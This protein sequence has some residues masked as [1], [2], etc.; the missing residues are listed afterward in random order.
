MRNNET[1]PLG[2]KLRQVRKARNVSQELI[3]NATQ[4]TI[5][6]VSHME[7]G[8]APCEPDTLLQIKKVLNVETMPLLDSERPAFKDR[9]LNFYDLILEWKNEEAKEIGKEL[10]DIKFLPFERELNTYYNLFNSRLL[11]AEGEFDKATEILK[12]VERYLP[13]ADDELTFYYY[14]TMGTLNLRTFHD[15]VA[16]DFFIKSSDLMRL[17]YNGHALLQFNIAH[18]L[19]RLGFLARS[20]K[21]LEKWHEMYSGE[22]SYEYIGLWVDD[23]LAR[24]YIRLNHL[25][26]AKELLDKCF[27]KAKLFNNKRYI[28]M[29]FYDYGFMYKT[30]GDGNSAIEYLNKALECFEEGE[31][32]YMEVLY[33]KVLCCID[34]KYSTLCKELIEEGRKLAKGSEEYTIFF[35]SA[36]HLTSLS[37]HKS[38]Q[39]IEGVTIPY[40][41]SNFSFYAALVYSEALRKYFE[42]KGARF[43]KK[44]LQMSEV[45]R[46]VYERMLGGGEF[47]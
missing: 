28:G 33:L 19:M 23:M 13:E 42:S 1:L 4:Y 30:A 17:N 6:N 9:L 25:K 39:H 29:I 5:G 38:T 18:C 40:L 8:K 36:K 37:D 31:A 16:M 12:T 3:A 11:I 22:Q 35:E 24:N 26:D 47:E 15:E 32:N 21:S 10:S 7:K 34:M 43:I 14:C 41:L 20:I 27:K 2:E 46:C 45:S 44:A